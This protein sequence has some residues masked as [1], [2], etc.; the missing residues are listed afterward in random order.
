ANDKGIEDHYRVMAGALPVAAASLLLPLMAGSTGAVIAVFFALFWVGSPAFAWLISRS[1][2]TED[3]LEVDPA[4]AA[5]LRRI[6]RRTWLY[7]ET[8]VTAEHNMLPPDNF[9]ETPAP[10][11]AARTSPTNVGMYLLASVSARDFGWISLNET[12]D[13]LDRTLATMEK[14]ER[15]RGHLYN[16]YDTRTLKPL[17]P[18]YVS[19]VDSGNLAGH[20][21]A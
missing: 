4:D 20:L 8:F 9:Q 19:S 12:A 7:F 13:R 16:W 18:L 15:H 3:R 14:M 17:H 11:V 2:E 5:A 6:A 10:I 21:V 1:A